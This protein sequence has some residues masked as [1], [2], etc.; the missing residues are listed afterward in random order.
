MCKFLLDNL[1]MLKTN[2][3]IMKN[4]IIEP[5]VTGHEFLEYIIHYFVYKQT[6]NYNSTHEMEEEDVKDYAQLEKTVFS[7]PGYTHFN[8]FDISSVFKIIK[9]LEVAKCKSF[10][11]GK[12]ND[13]E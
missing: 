9:E 13:Y 12:R 2:I 11:F 1:S 7:D 5:M 4:E 6:L 3:L 8:D 10:I